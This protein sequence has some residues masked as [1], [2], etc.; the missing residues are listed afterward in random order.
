MSSPDQSPKPTQEQAWLNYLQHQED[1]AAQNRFERAWLDD[2]LGMDALDGL[3]ML[4]PQAVQEDNR[5]IQHQ[6]NA[7]IQKKKKAKRKNESQL[8]PFWIIGA[9]LLVLLLIV[10]AWLVLSGF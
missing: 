9:V 7:L 1:V 8:M 4:D 6:L 2:P 10:L 5:L 3:H